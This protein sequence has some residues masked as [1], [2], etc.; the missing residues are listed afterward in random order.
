[1]SQCIK[2]TTT[3]KQKRQDKTKQKKESLQQK[4][5]LLGEL[6]PIVFPEEGCTT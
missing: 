2:T 6:G 5:A 3:T 4:L 1:M